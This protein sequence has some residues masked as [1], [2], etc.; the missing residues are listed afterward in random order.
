MALPIHIPS[1]DTKKWSGIFPGWFSGALWKAF[2]VDTEK[3]PGKII[4][5]KRMRAYANSTTLANLGVQDAFIFTNA[6]GSEKFWGLSR[7]GRMFNVANSIAAWAQDAIAGTPTD[8][9]DMAIH[10]DANGEDRLVVTGATNV[11][12]LNS[13]NWANVWKNWWTR[14]AI[15]SSTNATPIEITTSS[16]HGF[17]TGDKV[18]IVGHTVNLAANGT[19]IVTWV[20]ATK[21][22]LDSS[23]GSG[24]GGTTGYVGYLNLGGS[25][26]GTGALSGNPHPVDIFNR[27]AI[28]GDG[29]YVHTMDRD[30]SVSYKRLTLPINLVIQHIMHNST[31]VWFLCYNRSSAE[32]GDGAVVEWDGT[33]SSYLRV[34]PVYAAAAISG[35]I[36]NDIPIIIN[37]R[38]LIMRFNGSGFSEVTRFPVFYEDQKDFAYGTVDNLTV[39]PRGMF[40]S[41][42]LVYIA[43]SSI[44]NTSSI[45]SKRVN[46]GVW[47]CDLVTKDLRHKWSF[48]QYAGGDDLD[49]GHSVVYRVG[50]LFPLDEEEKF[51]ASAELYSDYSGTTKKFIYCL[52]KQHSSGRGYFITPRIT[53]PEVEQMWGD[54][55]I[56][57][58]KF[59]N[60]GNR[61][62]IKSRGV[63]P[64]IDTDNQRPLTSAATWVNTTSFTA[65]VPTGVAIG[66][67]VEIVA[68]DN[69]GCCPHITNLSATPNGVA[70]ITVTVDAVP[71]ASTKGFLARY[72]RWTK[73]K[74]I[75]SITLQ[76]DKS[77]VKVN[78]DY[79]QL[80]IEFYGAYMEI[81]ELILESAIN[82]RTKA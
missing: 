51:F 18:T 7:N 44:F 64:L 76:K 29:R 37:G 3:Y 72:D 71:Y 20:S 35:C 12:I 41:D 10:E 40:Y 39:K 62:I 33:S 17:I 23:V 43:I 70:T 56:K 14:V 69:A 42:G 25:D 6:G 58:R 8:C 30:D 54:L 48:T 1:L 4:L 15:A 59:T 36:A 47:V 46:A 60:S 28:I 19:W 31:R 5:S 77:P 53:T 82:Q 9:V 66:D 38:G 32:T 80:K 24:V 2:N 63:D 27:I 22:T 11:Y 61:I 68:G 74:T 50:A 16:A 21:F 67:E 65:I 26:V 78:S 79:C 34:H 81:D 45:M 49:F 13:L 57:F 52:N 55:W 73:E 75:S